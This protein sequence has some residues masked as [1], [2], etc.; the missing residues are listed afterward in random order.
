MKWLKQLFCKHKNYLV[1]DEHMID[2]GMRKLQRRY[3]W[4]CDKTYRRII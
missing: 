4:D 1:R 2:V 3:C